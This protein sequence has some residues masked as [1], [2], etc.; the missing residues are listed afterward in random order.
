MKAVIPD[1]FFSLAPAKRNMYTVRVYS[2]KKET[3]ITVSRALLTAIGVKHGSSRVAVLTNYSCILL[4]KGSD[5]AIDNSYSKH[6]VRIHIPYSI[7]IPCDTFN[8][9]DV[10][11][12]DG[13]IYIT[14]PEEL[15]P[16]LQR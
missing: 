14:L 16:Q 12:Q 4:T 3:R 9:T 2:T 15:F 5:V 8:C 6:R 13:G 10:K 1:G 11:V 7:M